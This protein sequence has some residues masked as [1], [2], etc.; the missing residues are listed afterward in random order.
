MKVFIQTDS[1]FEGLF[2]KMADWLRKLNAYLFGST[3][4]HGFKSHL[5][6]VSNSLYGEMVSSM[7]FKFNVP[8][9]MLN[10]IT[11]ERFPRTTMFG[12]VS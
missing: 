3:C 6:Y 10:K 9:L 12:M 4:L 5:R 11:E 8:S 1:L 7:D 2:N